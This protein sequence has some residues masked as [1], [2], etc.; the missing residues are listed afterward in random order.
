MGN[1]PVAA[2]DTV[3]VAVATTPVLNVVVL[4]PNSMQVYDPEP[5]LHEMD[6]PAA[7][8]AGPAT[9]AIELKVAAG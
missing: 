5:P 9:T 4:R 7:T 6:F 1:V 8:A 2:G 3:K